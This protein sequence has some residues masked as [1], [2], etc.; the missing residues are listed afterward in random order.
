M[1]PFV[2]DSS[3]NKINQHLE[4]AK[5]GF[6]AQSSRCA[7]PYSPKCVYR[8]GHAVRV[9]VSSSLLLRHLASALLSTKKLWCYRQV[10]PELFNF[11]ASVASLRRRQHSS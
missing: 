11:T 2:G 6:Y 10:T 7:S 1:K 4:Q 3:A 9:E 5:G 8:F